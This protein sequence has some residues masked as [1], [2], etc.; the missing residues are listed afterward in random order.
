[1]LEEESLNLLKE[2]KNLLAFSAGVDSSAL[3]FLLLEHKIDFD[4]AIVNYNIREQSKLEVAYAKELAKR[5]GFKY[6]IYETK[7]ITKNFESNARKIRYD[8]FE[9]IIEENHYENLLTAHHLGDRFEWM[10]MQFCKGAGC[11]EI[12]GMRVLES[13]DSYNII[14]PLLHLD[15]QEL[16]IYLNEH[17][18]K[19]FEDESNLDE[20]IKRNSFRHNYSKPLLDKYL[21]GIK[22]SFNYIDEDRD[23]L[24]KDITINKLDD[25]AY[26]INSKDNRIDI[27]HIDKYLKSVG[28]MMSGNERKILK[29][30]KTL[31]V[32]RKF[33]INKSDRFIFIAP[34]I[35]DS[36]MGKEFKESCR[37]LKIEPKLRAYFY[38]NKDIFLKVKKLLTTV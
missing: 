33:V 12:A 36:I 4:I 8:F 24:I 3:L 18:I 32:G 25:F 34:Y 28:F 29:D 14:R 6:H 9:T 31:I 21:T 37:I 30:K 38:E 22:K 11:A 35:K 13:R 2:K 27:Y 10:L 5:Y 16:L 7:K 17:N 15:K 20:A 23:R 26:F 1:M 19:Y